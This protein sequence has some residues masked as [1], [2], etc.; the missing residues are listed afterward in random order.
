ME[1][2]FDRAATPNRA[3]C[4]FVT[5]VALNGGNEHGEASEQHSNSE[6]VRYNS[7]SWASSSLK[8]LI[9]DSVSLLLLAVVPLVG[10]EE[11]AGPPTPVMAS[12]SRSASSVAN[13]L[14]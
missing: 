1:V 2:F 7:M 6:H 10:L 12:F 8:S 11:D 9:E 13:R 5:S 14:T 3:A 4:S